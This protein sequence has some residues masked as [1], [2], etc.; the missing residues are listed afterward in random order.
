M[1]H[2]E[3]GWDSWSVRW[4]WDDLARI[5]GWTIGDAYRD[6]HSDGFWLIRS[7]ASAS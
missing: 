2:E 3:K 4:S 1:N 5:T 7:A 6:E